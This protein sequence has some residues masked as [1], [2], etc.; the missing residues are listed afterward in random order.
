MD[1]GA[2]GGF[3]IVVEND[4]AKTTLDA[5]FRRVSSQRKRPKDVLSATMEL[6]GRLNPA[7][8]LPEVLQFLSMGKMT[9]VLTIV[10]GNYSVALSIRQGRMVNSSSLGRSRRL[11]QL[12]VN[13]NL[14]SRGSLDEA[15]AYQRKQT[16]PPLLGQVLLDRHLITREQLRQAIR[17]QL[18]EEMWDL[19]SLQEGSFKFEHST[20][21]AIGEVLVEVDIEPLIMEGTRRLDEW[22]RIVKNIPSEDSIPVIRPLEDTAEREAMQFSDNEWRVLSLVNGFYSAASL[23]SRSGIGKFETFRVLNSFLASGHVSIRT[24][25]PPTGPS[26]DNPEAVA[27][28]TRAGSGRE[29]APPAGGAAGEKTDKA[30]GS[31]SARLVALFRKKGPAEP[32]EHDG[33]VITLEKPEVRTPARFVSPVGFAAAFVNNVLAQL[34]A[35]PDF[36]VGASDLKLA[37]YYWRGVVMTYPKADLVEGQGNMLDAAKFERFV[38]FGGVN[39]PFRPIYE[40]TLEALT[41]CLRLLFLVAAQRLSTRTAQ[42]LFNEILNEMRARSTIGSSEDFYFQDFAEKIVS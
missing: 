42:R 11:G 37:E 36:T 19:F 17:L 6:E 31:S 7:L 26:P 14:V 5:P 15:L 1:P 21:N 22:A 16:P 29:A 41:R 3:I 24:D 34:I 30:V 23:A 9:G 2:A 18:E 33:G 8:S 10:Q 28:A 38:E 12:L 20:E 25:T 13:R 32:V 4:P 27:A 35:N 40:D 39:G